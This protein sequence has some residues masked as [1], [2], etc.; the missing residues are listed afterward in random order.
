MTQLLALLVAVLALVLARR[1][2]AGQ[3][4]AVAAVCAAA[5]A[6]AAELLGAGL[7]AVVLGGAALLTS[8]V[9]LFWLWTEDDR[10]DAGL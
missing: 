1:A 3:R 9:L 5:G 2:R 6:V 7:L 8:V 10:R 4:I